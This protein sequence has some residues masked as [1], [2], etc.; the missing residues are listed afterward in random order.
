[1]VVYQIAAR[2]KLKLDWR[3]KLLHGEK[4]SC[5]TALLDAK[6]RRDKNVQLKADLRAAKDTL[7][8]R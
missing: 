3:D 6:A 5:K 2:T 8:F 7:E 1:M 4:E